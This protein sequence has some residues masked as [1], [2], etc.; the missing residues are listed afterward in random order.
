M[1]T[2]NNFSILLLRVKNPT[3]LNEQ[4]ARGMDIH[5]LESGKDNNKDIMEMIQA[6][7]KKISL[8]T[9][10]EDLITIVRGYGG[11]ASILFRGGAFYPRT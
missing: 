6:S 8:P 11:I 5:I 9:N 1:D 3:T 4:Q 2:P 7:K 10:I